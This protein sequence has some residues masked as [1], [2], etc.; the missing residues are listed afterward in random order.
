MIP[1]KPKCTQNI[2]LD[3]SCVTNIDTRGCSLLP[4]LEDKV[5]A[6]GGRLCLVVEGQVEEMVERSGVLH[7]VEFQVYPTVYDAVELGKLDRKHRKNL[8]SEIY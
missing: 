7:M 6:G 8:S 3:L 2:I 4:W 5:K 1:D